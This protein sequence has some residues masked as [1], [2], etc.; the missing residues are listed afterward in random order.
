MVESLRRA[1][2]QLPDPVLRRSVL[3]S[4]LLALAMIA[5]AAGFSWWLIFRLGLFGQGLVDGSVAAGVAALVL[6]FGTLL[7]FPSTVMFI[8]SWFGDSVADAVEARY[9]PDLGPPRDR[10]VRETLMPG[11]SLL[12][13]T[14]IVNLVLLPVYALT[15]IVPGLGLVIFYCV[16]GYLFGREFFEAVAIRRMDTKSARALRRR[17]RGRILVAGMIITVLTTIPILNLAAPV[18][19]TAFMTNVCHGLDESTQTG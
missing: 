1:F 6:V 14:V 18:L 15:L 5:L 3:L 7:F 11:L 2:A 12:V 8:A 13:V 9:W 19:A 10:T 4:V 16:N 17:Y